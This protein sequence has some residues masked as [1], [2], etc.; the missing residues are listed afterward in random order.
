MILVDT[1]AL[2]AAADASHPQH[3][4][5]ADAIRD[6]EP[7]ILS[8]LVLA[9]ADYLLMT[10]AGQAGEMAFLEQAGSGAFVIAGFD[11]NDI[12]EGRSIIEQYAA[13][14]LGLADAS[15]VVLSRRYR[16]LD[17]VTLDERHF[18]TVLGHQ[19]RPFRIMPADG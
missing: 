4:S 10:R 18:R 9:E 12:R 16:C 11:H 5:C 17:L 15:L 3:S 7:R 8:P 13:L 19:G 2:V 1:S 14:S 6:G